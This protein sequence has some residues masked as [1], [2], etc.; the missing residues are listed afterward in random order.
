MGCW[1]E[2]CGLSGLAI[3]YGESV[4]LVVTRRFTQ[5]PPDFRFPDSIF[6]PVG[7]PVYGTYDDYGSVEDVENESQVIEAFGGEPDVLKHIERGEFLENSYAYSQLMFKRDIFDQVVEAVGN[8]VP[9]YP[10]T[11]V[12]SYMQQYTEMHE[13]LSSLDFD[14]WRSVHDFEMKSRSAILTNNIRRYQPFVKYN[15]RERAKIDVLDRAL[16]MMRLSWVPRAGAGSQDMETELPTLVAK[17]V[18]N[19][20]E[21]MSSDNDWDDDDLG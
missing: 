6:E 21:R 4:A 13:G 20:A 5:Y 15:A 14:D 11:E 16:R 8:Q 17:Y 18:I 7:F 12:R 9:S 2:T 3:G 10:V 19:E 1:N